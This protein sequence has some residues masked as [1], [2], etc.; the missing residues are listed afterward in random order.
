MIV[1]ASRISVRKQ[2]ALLKYFAQDMLASHAAEIAKVSA[3]TVNHYYRHFREVIFMSLRRAPRFFGEV[4][5][6]QAFVGG[7]GGKGMREALKR[8]THLPHKE[9]VQRAK[10][11]RKDRKVQLFGIKQRGG[12]IYVQIIK[13]A[14]RD[15]LMPIVRLV[16]EQGST[17]LTDKW[18]GFEELGLDGYTHK[19]INHSESYVDKKG[20]HIN[21]VEQFWSFAKRRLAKFNGIARTTLPLHVKE[22]EWRYNHDRKDILSAL[23]KLV[24]ESNQSQRS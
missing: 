19:S 23:K 4:E 20:N 12:D 11:I 24:L 16:V 14:D 13:R 18:R 8:I 22:C 1:R 10:D 21:G 15:T 6:D 9:Y 17:V 5:M 7:R 2:N 3:N